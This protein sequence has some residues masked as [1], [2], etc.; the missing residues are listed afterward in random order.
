MVILN[1]F[2]KHEQ[3]INLLELMPDFHGKFIKRHI[4]GLKQLI[5]T[6]DTFQFIDPQNMNKIINFLNFLKN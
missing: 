4:N 5:V 3:M 1:G 6:N 2:G